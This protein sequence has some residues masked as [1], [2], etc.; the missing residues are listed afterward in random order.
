MKFGQRELM[1]RLYDEHEG[2]RDKVIAEYAKLD[3]A[4]LVERKKDG[5]GTSSIEY[6]VRLWANGKYH[7]WLSP[8]LSP[9]KKS[10]S[11]SKKPSSSS[12]FEKEEL[13][14]FESALVALGQSWKNNPERPKPRQQSVDYW[15]D[16]IH[17]WSEDSSL[18]ILVRKGSL[19]ALK[20]FHRNGRTVISCDNSPAHWAFLGCFGD[21]TPTL[22]DIEH[23]LESG[24]LPITMA[25]NRAE[26]ALIEAGDF[27]P[28]GGYINKSIYGQV[29]RFP[30]NKQYKLCHLD[31]VGIN[32]R[33][34]AETLEE[35]VLKSHMKRFLDPTN[36]IIVPIRYSGIGECE[37]F[38]APFRENRR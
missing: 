21:F 26:K 2:D 22:E 37:S 23:Q 18:P 14:E 35:E 24:Q 27:E 36:M 25:R 17:L 4:G 13:V 10:V 9:T 11:N 6:A 16:L 28:I 3:E 7:G 1:R 15:S 32:V 8:N 31:R 12:K 5:S 29:N 38:L 30:N 20:K 34:E 33:G 19:R